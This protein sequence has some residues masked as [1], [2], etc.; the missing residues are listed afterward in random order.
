MDDLAEAAVSSLLPIPVALLPVLCFLGLLVLLD[1][2]KLVPLNRV[3]RSVLWGVLAALVGMLVNQT[4]LA[5][6]GLSMVAY[7]RYVAPVI[8]ELLKA[9]PVIW[10]IRRQRCGFLVDAA[11]HG[12]AV[13]AG[14]AV[15]ENVY[16]LYSLD[17][18]NIFLWIVRGFGT[19]IMH[20]STTTIFAILAK[21]LCERHDSVAWRWFLPGLAAAALIH[22]G[23]NHFLLPP[24]ATTALLLVVFPLL[25]MVVFSESEKATRGWLGMGFDTDAAL[26]EQVLSGEVRGSRVG[27]YLLE[28]RER[29]PGEVVADMLCMLQINLELSMRAKGIL[30][31]RE[32]GISVPIGDDVRPKLE[33]LEYLE[34][35]VGVTGKIAMQPFLQTSSRDL[36]Q[37]YVL[38][39]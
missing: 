28:L 4:L 37:L 5:R 2:F 8:E 36:W 19:A 35:S 3:L 38:G 39:K 1:S 16:Y 17:S 30:M 25:V 24:L 26:L 13:G 14:F 10:L 7:T 27:Q 34:K 6:W 11:I 23:F 32:A 22:S 21:G 29:F 15:I 33:E 18:G 12:F 20:G 31:A 9:L